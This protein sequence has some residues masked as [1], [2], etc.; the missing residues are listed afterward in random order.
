MP[1][2]SKNYSDWLAQ[3]TPSC[4]VWGLLQQQRD[5]RGATPFR[6]LTSEVDFY[7]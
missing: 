6:F 3:K 7:S 2:S 5:L 1:R 4:K